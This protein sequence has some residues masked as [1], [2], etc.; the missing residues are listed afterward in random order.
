MTDCVQRSRLGFNQC[1][2]LF[3]A[4]RLQIS[5]P[6]PCRIHTVNIYFFCLDSQAEKHLE[7][8]RAFAGIPWVQTSRDNMESTA[9]GIYLN[10]VGP[11]CPLAP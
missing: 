2:V 8:H 4:H 11:S 10:D 6:F 3:R 5:I 1:T 9:L 7:W